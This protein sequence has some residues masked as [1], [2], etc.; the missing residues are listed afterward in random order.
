MRLERKQKTILIVLLVVGILAI[1]IGFAAFSNNLNIVPQAKVDPTGE[2]FQVV[3]SNA[4]NAIDDEDPVT[5]TKTPNTITATNGTIDNTTNPTLSNLS[6]SFTEPGQKVEYNLYVYNAGA[7]VA[8][9]NSV[10]FKGT[11]SCTPANN[12]VNYVDQACNSIT[13]TVKIGNS[14]YG[15]TTQN[16][17]G[18]SLNPKGYETVKVTIEYASNGALADGPFT[19]NFPDVSLYYVTKTG[20]NEQV[21]STFTGTIYR[22]SGD[23]ISIG[24]SISALTN[25]YETSQSSINKNYYLKHEVANDIVTASYACI[26]YTEGVQK[27]ACLRGGDG[28]A[29]YGTYDGISSS[30]I[31]YVANLNPTGNLAI[32]QSTRSYF[33]G[34]GGSCSFR[35]SNSQ[36]SNSSFMLSAG[37]DGSLMSYSYG[38]FTRCLVLANGSSFCFSSH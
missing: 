36:C 15:S 11:K 18:H 19:V 17:T 22:N 8:N 32:L 12:T 28:G 20:V 35:N 37:S 10:T 25:A 34:S 5:P 27:E 6:T 4:N 16:I 24:G 29:S 3:F 30:K 7:Y 33:V 9:L 21:A 31:S 23:M 1:S 38:D 14:T 2:K 26:R 13:M